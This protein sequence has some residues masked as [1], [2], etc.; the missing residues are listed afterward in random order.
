MGNASTRLAGQTR[1]RSMVEG[2]GPYGLWGNLEWPDDYVRTVPGNS[3]LELLLR[4][5]YEFIE[6]AEYQVSLRY[7]YDPSSVEYKGLEIPDYIT[8][9][10]VVSSVRRISLPAANR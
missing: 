10:N 3:H 9:T 8:R 4:V 7:H 2:G 1:W 6:G 5:P